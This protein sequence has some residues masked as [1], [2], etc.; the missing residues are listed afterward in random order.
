MSSP[1]ARATEIAAARGP[2]EKPVQKPVATR[3]IL[4]TRRSST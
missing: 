3:V 4:F 2:G 1:T